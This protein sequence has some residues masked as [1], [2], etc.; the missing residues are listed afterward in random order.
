MSQASRSPVATTVESSVFVIAAEESGD[1]LGAALVGALRERSRGPLRFSGVGGRQMHK[2]GVPSLFPIEE[3][4]I[5]G[6]AEIPLRLPT[7]LARIR[8]A[9]DAVLKAAPD[10]LV[11]IDSPDFT[12]RVARRVRASNPRIPIIDYVCPSVWA[13]RPWSTCHATLHRPRARV[14]AV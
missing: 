2:A 8:H 12:H 6:F 7:I 5:L 4:A 14:A 13:W 10:V 11:I 1:R 9:A 3:L